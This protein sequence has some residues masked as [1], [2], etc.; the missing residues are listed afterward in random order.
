MQIGRVSMM[1]LLAALIAMPVAYAQLN[2]LMEGAG[3]VMT[4][5]GPGDF[6]TAALPH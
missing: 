1:V 4:A 5:F 3:L 2:A 6:Q